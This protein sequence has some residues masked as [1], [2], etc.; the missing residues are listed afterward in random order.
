MSNAKQIHATQDKFWPPVVNAK[1]ASSTLDHQL[2][3]HVVLLVLPVLQKIMNGSQRK[4]SANHANH[5]L[6]VK[7]VTK[8]VDQTSAISDPNSVQMVSARNA[9]T[10]PE[11]TVA[12]SSELSLNANQTSAQETKC[13]KSMEHAV[14]ATTIKKLTLQTL[15]VSCQYAWQLEKSYSSQLSGSNARIILELIH[16]AEFAD[17]THALWDKS[18]W[19]MELAKTAQ[20]IR[21]PTLQEKPAR[22]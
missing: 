20:H 13:S 8:F 16:Y 3:T 14:F 12:K 4:V 22:K 17:Q 1:I 2:L 7:M 5:T 10:S 6:E 11:E 9:K 18:C 21:E 15:N 19:K